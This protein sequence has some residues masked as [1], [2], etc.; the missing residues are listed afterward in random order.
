MSRSGGMAAT[1]LILAG[2]KQRIAGDQ[3][4]PV[5][6]EMENAS[7]I[8][9]VRKSNTLQ[10]ATGIA[11]LD[12]TSR[13]ARSF[14]VPGGDLEA[15]S[16]NVLFLYSCRYLTKYCRCANEAAVLSSSVSQPLNWSSRRR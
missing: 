4:A 1:S 10:P 7:G 5:S 12:L 6:V 3:D 13:S 11:F 9:V 14:T 8:R 15:S 2:S 16:I